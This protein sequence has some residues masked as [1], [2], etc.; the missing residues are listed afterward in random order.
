MNFVLIRLCA[1]QNSRLLCVLR[2]YCL[3]STRES[4][5]CGTERKEWET[6]IVSNICRT[7]SAAIFIGTKPTAS[8]TVLVNLA[9]VLAEL[10]AVVR[11]MRSRNS[12]RTIGD[13]VI[14]DYDVYGGKSAKSVEGR[15][16]KHGRLLC[17]MGPWAR[18]FY[19]YSMAMHQ[20]SIQKAE[21]GLC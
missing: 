6:L 8:N 7:I 16:R 1:Q 11:D 9:T 17:T 10:I 14:G 4:A 13:S 21:R 3:P 2:R 20:P 18:A 15:N 5:Y 12:V 19:L